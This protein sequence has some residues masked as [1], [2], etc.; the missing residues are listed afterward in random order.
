MIENIMHMNIIKDLFPNHYKAE[1]DHDHNILYK[2]SI[3]EA[4]IAAYIC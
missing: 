4:T 2:T 3:L 1:S